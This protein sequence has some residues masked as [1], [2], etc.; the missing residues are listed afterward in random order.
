MATI[1]TSLTAEKYAE[2][3]DNDRPTELVEGQVLV[4][5]PPGP[6]HGELCARISY[7]LQRFLEVHAL[8]RVLTNDSGVVTER[9]PDTVR[10]ADVAYYS[11]QRVPK[12]PMPAGLVSVAPELVFEVFSPSDRWSDVHIKVAEYLHAGVRAVCVVDDSTKS[13]HVFHSDRPSQVVGANEEFSLPEILP[14]FQ[15]RVQQIFE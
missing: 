2:L 9:N 10:G 8:G 11:F 4:M 12:G 15:L 3:P 13:L 1:T 6:R 14:E 5:A 7:F